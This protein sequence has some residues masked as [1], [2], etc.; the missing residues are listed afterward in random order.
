M[1]NKIQI[2]CT[3][4]ISNSFIQIAEANN[5]CIDE[6]N[7]IKTEE[8]IS[9]QTKNRILQ[10]SGQNITVIFT[11]SNAVNAVG[12]IAPGKVNWKIYC[13]EP[14]TRKSVESVF[15]RA[16][17]IG[18][19]TDAAQL[20]EI[21]I[22]DQSLNQVVFFCGNLR[23][24]LLPDK[25]KSHGINVEEIIVYHTI[26][27]SQSISKN[28]EGI[29]FFSPSAVK[30]F[31]SINKIQSHTILF[32]IGK[33]TAEEVKQYSN[34]KIIISDIPGTQKLIAEVI[35]YFRQ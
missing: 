27:N 1:Q 34:N 6:L 33:T 21:I 15:R 18:S 7:F 13:I 32:A 20:S 10:L 29:L 30:S 22:E 5:I 23:K 28:Y 25:L 2:L 4:K 19:A 9:A 16:S 12:K 17:I 35:K 3:K 8:S 24:D 14:A 11:S 26:E 31:F